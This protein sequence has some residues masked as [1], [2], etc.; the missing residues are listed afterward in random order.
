M[1]RSFGLLL[2][3]ALV[4]LGCSRN[5]QMKGRVVFEDDG[6]P[7]TVGIVL[8]CSPTMQ[9]RGSL[10]KDGYFVIGTLR[11]KDGL[12]P[13]TY[14]VAIAGAVEDLPDG[15]FRALL[16]DKWYS[17]TTSGI[18]LTIDKSIKDYEIKVTRPVTRSV[19]RPRAR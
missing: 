12:P 14:T 13:G 7:L 10:D 4:A 15:N 18:T 3:F 17:P 8:L 5:F 19:T 16:E 1:T 2:L 9:S 6:S 11:D